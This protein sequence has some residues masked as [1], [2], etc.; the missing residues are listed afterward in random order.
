MKI[1]YEN[2]NKILFILKELFFILQKRRKKQFLLLIIFS[3]IASVLE[4]LSLGL[5]VPF[6]NSIINPSAILN[7]NLIISL[8]KSIN[9]Y[10][11]QEIIFIL[12]SI[13]CFITLLCGLFRVFLTFFAERI[14]NINAAEFCIEIF[15]KNIHQPYDKF[16]KK[17]S[18]ETMALIQKTEEVYATISYSVS[19]ITSFFIFFTVLL[20]LMWLNFK[21]IFICIIFFVLFYTIIIFF[22]KKKLAF[23]SSIIS[24]EHYF[25]LKILQESLGSIRDILL[26]KTQHV[27]VDNFKK[28]TLNRFYKIAELK[29]IQLMPRF[30]LESLGVILIS[31]II[32]FLNKW[33]GE[34]YSDIASLAVVAFGAQRLIPCLN[35]MYNSYAAIKGNISSLDEIILFYKT[36]NNISSDKIISKKLNFSKNIIFEK[37]SFTFD[38]KNYLLEEISLNISKGDKIGIVGKTGT[39]K[40]TFLD[41]FMGLLTPTSGKLSV[42]GTVISN[43]NIHL[44]Q[45]KISHVPQQIYLSDNTIAENIAF[46]I[47][48]E[49]ID[50][51]KVKFYAKKSQISEFID[52]TDQK[53]QT[54]VGER[55]IKLS[56][57]Q[58]QRIG[59]ARALYK[60]PQIIIFDE[61]TNALDSETE[62]K[63]MESIYNLNKEL[64]IILVAHRIT[65]LNNCNKL[66][67]IQNKKIELVS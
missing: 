59:I 52:Q 67:K 43:D 47:P 4:M 17:N 40:S 50:M 51:E 6:L 34:I 64:T 48:I 28:S 33:Q 58:R 18:S 65:T 1:F 10:K 9:I 26:D 5:L 7:N 39:G 8:F 31:G 42:D 41:I 2:S 12:A 24:K 13:F 22:T 57:G 23:N 38:Q 56:G 53:Y 27:Y 36:N 20:F 15:S 55:G 3:I 61:A 29:F 21:I 63:V 19:F 46:G 45:K 30:L 60:E 49:N 16:I 25:G 54:I 11:F 44:W 32:F 62:L 14:S 35:N 37:V 66:F